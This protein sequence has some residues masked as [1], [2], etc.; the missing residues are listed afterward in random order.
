MRSDEE[1]RLARTV[2]VR[3]VYS[4]ILQRKVG[5]VP[6]HSPFPAT[7]GIASGLLVSF[8]LTENGYD[9]ELLQTLV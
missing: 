9:E 8:P 2:V 6:P 5:V 4:S 1:E 7:F 3:N